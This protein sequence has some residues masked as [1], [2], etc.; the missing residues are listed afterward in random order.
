MPQGRDVRG[1]PRLWAPVLALLTF[2]GT[3]L[4]HTVEYLRVN[5]P[6]GLARVMTSS[7][8]L[9]MLPLGAV[10]LVAA[11]VGGVAWL[12]AVRVL[13]DRVANGLLPTRARRRRRA[14]R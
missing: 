8:H 14:R 9:Y 10:L 1:P 6:H 5:G 3:W 2:V 12:K 4:T 11:A 7:V 13:A